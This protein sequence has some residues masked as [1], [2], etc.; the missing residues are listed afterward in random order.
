MGDYIWLIKKRKINCYIVRHNYIYDKIILK[1]W[2]R[3]NVKLTILLTA[4]KEAGGEEEEPM[5]R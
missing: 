4:K 2:E 3:I 1:S 5:H